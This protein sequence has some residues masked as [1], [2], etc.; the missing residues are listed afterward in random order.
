MDTIDW[1]SKAIL[2]KNLGMILLQVCFEL[3]C[4]KVGSV[5]YWTFKKLLQSRWDS[6]ATI[7]NVVIEVYRDASCS[8]FINIELHLSENPEVLVSINY[9]I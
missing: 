4:K 8:G 2:I 9:H 6:A 3:D 5:D 7:N 1:S